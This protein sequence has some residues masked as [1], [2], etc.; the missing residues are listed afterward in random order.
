MAVVDRF[1]GS[2]AAGSFYGYQFVV[3]KVAN[4]NNVFT[5]DSGGAGTAITEG[6]Y[7]KGVR[8]FAQISSLIVLGTQVAATMT[9]IVDAATVNAGPGGTTSGAYG[10][11][12]DAMASAVG[13][14]AGDYTVTTSTALLGGGTFTFA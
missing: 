3:I 9:V 14:S 4:S 7:S 5:A 13:G 10:A 8:A 12:K 2:P 11:L 1:N 6:G